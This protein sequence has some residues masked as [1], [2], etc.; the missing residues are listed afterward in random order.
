MITSGMPKVGQGMFIRIGEKV[1][2]G[3]CVRNV[4]KSSAPVNRGQVYPGLG[5]MLGDDR[6]EYWFRKDEWESFS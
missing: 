3:R 6:R 5:I 4:C 2:T 1:V